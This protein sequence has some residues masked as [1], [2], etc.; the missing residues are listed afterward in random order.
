VTGIT[1]RAPAR[2]VTAAAMLVLMEEG[3]DIGVRIGNLPDSSMRAV[4]VGAS[5]WAYLAK[6][7]TPATPQDLAGHDSISF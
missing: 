7:G 5:S 4:R 1:S 6:R 3:L 2:A